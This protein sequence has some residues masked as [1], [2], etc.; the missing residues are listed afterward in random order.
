VTP[1]SLELKEVWVTG[2]SDAGIP[3]S[4][5][6][7]PRGFRVMTGPK[8]RCRWRESLAFPHPCRSLVQV[9]PSAVA[10]IADYLLDHPQAPL[11]LSIGELAQQAVASPATVTRFWV[12]SFRTTA[13]GWALGL[14]RPGFCVAASM[15]TALPLDALKMALWIRAPDGESVDGL[16]HHSDA[17][18]QY[19]A[20]RYA[21]RLLDAGALA[22]IGT[23]GGQSRQRPSGIGGGSVQDRVRAPRRPVPRRGRAGAGHR[24]LG[25]VV[26]PQPAPRVDRTCA[27]G[28]VRGRLQRVAARHRSLTCPALRLLRRRSCAGARPGQDRSSSPATRAAGAPS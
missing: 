20:I 19:T 7:S 16:I 2:P 6:S 1:R 11:T 21:E 3:D 18:S 13:M 10:R 4:T 8:S 24:R 17:G 27:A 23:V 12:A 5:A 9:M 22:S 28:R 15:P 14:N 25:V 26:Q